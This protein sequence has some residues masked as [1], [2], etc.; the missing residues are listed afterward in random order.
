M[1]GALARNANKRRPKGA[2]HISV[3]RLP[4]HVYI[5]SDFFTD[6]V[7]PTP[8]I[9]PAAA[10]GNT[11]AREEEEEGGGEAQRPPS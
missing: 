7:A 9:P 1:V 10:A 6:T 3:S 2:K 4:I 11:A 8:T 5:V